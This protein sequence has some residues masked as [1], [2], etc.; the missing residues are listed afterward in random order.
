MTKFQK[1][2]LII[3]SLALVLSTIWLNEHLKQ[4][5]FNNC[6]YLFE[7]KAFTEKNRQK[8]HVEE[9]YQKCREAILNP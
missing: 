1:V 4:R 5:R 9:A 6:K 2:F 3:T 7:E 8:S